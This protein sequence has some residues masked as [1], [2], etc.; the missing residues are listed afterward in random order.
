M[1]G[2]HL[3]DFSGVRE[4]LGHPIGLYL[5]SDP[6]V[7]PPGFPNGLPTHEKFRKNPFFAP[8]GHS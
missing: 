8:A 1:T 4:P 2:Y 3:K 6:M 5:H 7:G